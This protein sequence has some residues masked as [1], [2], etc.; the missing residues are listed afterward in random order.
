MT[1]LLQNSV[2]DV[3]CIYL[4]TNYWIL[5]IAKISSDEQDG[6]FNVMSM[7]RNGSILAWMTTTKYTKTMGLVWPG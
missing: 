6:G 4:Y 3:T 5:T 1:T 7:S 2:S